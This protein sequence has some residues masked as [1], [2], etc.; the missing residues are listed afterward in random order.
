MVERSLKKYLVNPWFKECQR[1]HYYYAYY[2]HKE[3]VTVHGES[4]RVIQSATLVYCDLDR[5]CLGRTI[6]VV[7]IG[8]AG[9]FM[10]D[11]FGPARLFMHPDPTFLY[12]YT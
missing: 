4:H 3:R 5:L 12:R 7:I 6:F 1:Y 8:Q 11:I 9:P 10:L 2:S